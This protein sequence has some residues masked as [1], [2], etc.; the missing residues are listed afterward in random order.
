MLS[1][2]SK[3]RRIMGNPNQRPGAKK[4]LTSQPP[5]V[6]PKPAETKITTYVRKSD[7][8]RQDIIVSRDRVFYNSIL[9]KRSSVGA[10]YTEE[11]LKDAIS[12]DMIGLLET[13]SDEY[14]LKFF[15]KR[16]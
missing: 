3:K 10:S 6:A 8:S 7:R 5:V 1:Y 9:V 11:I 12:T 4:T 2:N 14:K 16:K 15:D 13:M